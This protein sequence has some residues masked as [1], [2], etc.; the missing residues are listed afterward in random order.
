M[1]KRLQPTLSCLYHRPRAFVANVYCEDMLIL[2]YNADFYGAMLTIMSKDK[3]ATCAVNEHG[4]RC[5]MRTV[6]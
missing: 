5:S 1:G 4:I 6:Q 3:S 2:F